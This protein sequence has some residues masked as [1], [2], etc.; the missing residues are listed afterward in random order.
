MMMHSGCGHGGHGR[1]EFGRLVPRGQVLLLRRRIGR[2][3][4]RR[5]RRRRV[6]IHELLAASVAVLAPATALAPLVA[7]THRI[8]S[9][10]VL[11]TA[12]HGR[13]GSRAGVVG[14]LHAIIDR[15]AV[16]IDDF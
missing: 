8:H 12:V 15:A 7:A 11:A 4:R 5:R 3:K 13:A 14:E 16:G 1:M 2:M 10:A 6:P 9:V